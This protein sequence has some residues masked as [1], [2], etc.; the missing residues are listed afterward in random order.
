MT[1][2]PT[3]VTNPTPGLLDLRGRTALVT[4]AASGI[5]AAC[6]RRLGAA[7]ARLVLVGIAAD[8]VAGLAA[9]L[10]ATATAC[11]LSDLAPGGP[12]GLGGGGGL[13]NQRGGRDV[14]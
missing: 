2:T 5:G 6:A 1:P 7:G 14:A 11:G 9:G 13:V 12:L 4:G 10:G 3:S 8:P